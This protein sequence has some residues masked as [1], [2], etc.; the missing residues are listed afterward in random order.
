MSRLQPQTFEKHSVVSLRPRSKVYHI[1]QLLNKT[2]AQAGLASVLWVVFGCVSEHSLPTQETAK[3]R[4]GSLTFTANV[5]FSGEKVSA[6]RR[7]FF[8]LP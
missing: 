4:V 2:H 3:V 7:P 5:F 8:T 6:W 1:R